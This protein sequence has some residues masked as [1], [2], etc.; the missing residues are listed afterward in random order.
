MPADIVSGMTL[1]AKRPARTAVA[2]TTEIRPQTGTDAILGWHRDNHTGPL[3]MCSEQPCNSVV[4]A[5]FGARCVATQIEGTHDFDDNGCLCPA[6]VDSPDPVMVRDLV[7]AWHSTAGH[8]FR[9]SL[10][11][12]TACMA[13]SRTVLDE[14]PAKG[15]LF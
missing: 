2:T 9:V 11:N 10:C 6:C 12:H 5:W 8:P 14:A 13:V 1:T 15:R 7:T 4:V 3:H